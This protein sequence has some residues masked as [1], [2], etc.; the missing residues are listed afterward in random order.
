MRRPRAHRRTARAGAFVGLR[1]SLGARRPWAA[2]QAQADARARSCARSTP[3]T[4][5]TSRSTS[6]GPARRAT[7]PA[8]TLT[9][10]G[11]SRSSSS[12]RPRS[13]TRATR[14]IV[15]VIDTSQAMDAGR[16]A[17]QRPRRRRRRSSTPAPTAPSSPSSRPAHEADL[18]S[19]L[20]TDR[21]RHQGRR[22]T[23]SRPTEGAVDLGCACASP[24]SCSRPSRTLQPNI[25]LAVGSTTAS[26]PRD[27]PVGRTA[28]LDA[29]ATCGPSSGSASMRTEPV[30]Q[31]RPTRPA[32]R[33]SPPTTRPPSA[34]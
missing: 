25:V 31:P 32:A 19:E 14:G 5:P 11:E 20:T 27:E 9:Q 4:R 28:V 15:F 7:S 30:R 13:I 17:D 34:G 29:G 18:K 21:S 16:R 10:N 8:P 6:S 12:R 3:P 33:S 2:R 1:A 24:A 26:A 22:S 23:A